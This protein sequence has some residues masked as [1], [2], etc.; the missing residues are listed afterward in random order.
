M[1]LFLQELQ[2]CNHGQKWF[3]RLKNDHR[4]GDLYRNFSSTCKHINNNNNN[5]AYLRTLNL[6]KTYFTG[7]VCPKSKKKR[8]PRP[9]PR[10][11]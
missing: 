9:G 11:M 2:R 3:G 1:F 4:S 10:I 6:L 5:L 7:E 8:E